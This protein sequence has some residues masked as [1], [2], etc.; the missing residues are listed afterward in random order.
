[1]KRSWPDQGPPPEFTCKN[2]LKTTKT[3]PQRAIS[4]CDPHSCDI[5]L[6]CD[7]VCSGRTYQTT[8]SHVWR[9]CQDNRCPPVRMLGIWWWLL[10]VHYN[11]CGQLKCWLRS[12]SKNLRNCLWWQNGLQQFCVEMCWP[13]DCVRT[14]ACD[15]PPVGVFVW[16]SVSLLGWEHRSIFVQ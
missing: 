16:L 13:G 2:W 10:F 9:Q 14:R 12:Y 3:K 7:S 6:E 15:K 5:L 4:I 8:I 1:M 11:V